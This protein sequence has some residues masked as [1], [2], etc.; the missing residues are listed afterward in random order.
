[1]KVPFGFFKS[2]GALTPA[3][4]SASFTSRVSANGG[5]LNPVEQSAILQL[6]T[7]LMA[8]GVWNSMKVIYP[9]VGG[10]ASSCA[11]NL[12]DSNYLGTFSS[13]WSFSNFGATPNG[14]NCYMLT[15]FN[16]FLQYSNADNTSFSY[17]SRTDNTFNSTEIGC[18]TSNAVTDR[19]ALSI[20]YG[21]SF[22]SDQNNY[23][24]GRITVSTG[25]TPTTGL[26]ATSRTSTSTMKAYKNGTQFGSTNVNTNTSPLPNC[27]L[28]VGAINFNDGINWVSTTRECAFA[29]AG[30]GLSDAQA[31]SLYTNV[32]SF[33]TSLG[34]AV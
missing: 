12:V 14:I 21:G 15:Q 4:I 13:G 19:V 5:S 22:S 7:D 33:Q 23:T 16:P 1:M 29:H 9:M 25:V 11:V 31:A 3:Q 8:S 26:Y 17:Y 2:N 10:N 28:T 24:N 6:V 18:Q 34:R 32:Q 20:Y 30:L 27:I